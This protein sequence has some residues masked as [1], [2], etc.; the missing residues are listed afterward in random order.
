MGLKPLTGE[1]WRSSLRTALA[2]LIA[3][4]IALHWGGDTGLDVWYCLYGVAR[5]NLAD[6]RLSAQAARD[7]LLGSCLGG[8]IAAG[9]VMLGNRW[10]LVGV[11]YLLVELVGKRWGLSSGSRTNAA[12]AALLLLLVPAYGQEGALWVVYRI[13]WYLLGLAIGMATERLLWARSERQRLAELERNLVAILRAV[14]QAPADP[15]A[16]AAAR[17][18]AEPVDQE[19]R[20]VCAFRQVREL[21]RQ[22]AA[23]DPDGWSRGGGER[24][25]RSLERAM[26]HGAALLRHPSH[27]ELA[28]PLARRCT[29][30]DR[31]A[32][33]QELSEL[34]APA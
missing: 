32:L 29:E 2:G 23:E 1:Q 25:L 4:P 7:Q 26:V 12:I 20:L 15:A 5:S 33:A 14:H 24:R 27:L 9:L 30:L 19:R 17:A 13:S 8:G 21:A 3:A 16:A 6:Q 18:A 34:G 22:V 11:A 10:I 28:G 31:S